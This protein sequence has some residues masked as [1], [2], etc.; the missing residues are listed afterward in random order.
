MFRRFFRDG[1]A[2]LQSLDVDIHEPHLIHTFGR[3]WA[4]RATQIVL[5]EVDHPSFDTI[6]T[7]ENLSI[8]WFAAGEFQRAAMHSSMRIAL[9]PGPCPQS[10]SSCLSSDLLATLIEAVLM[11]LCGC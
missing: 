5:L 1:S 11:T 3:P 8:Y 10:F 2:V 9:R 7:C 4:E 6:R